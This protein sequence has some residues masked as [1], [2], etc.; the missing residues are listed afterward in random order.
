MQRTIA[1][2]RRMLD[3][4]NLAPARRREL[5]REVDR[6][7]GERVALMHRHQVDHIA[8][9]DAT[10]GNVKSALYENKVKVRA[11]VEKGKIGDMTAAEYGARFEELRR[12]RERLVKQAES[13]ESRV[14]DVARMEDDAEGY[15]DELFERFP[16][17]R[18]D[19][20]F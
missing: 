7:V 5:Q 11:L 2:A 9:L 1:E 13:I 3:E 4:Q 15:L 19:F 20:P 14:E 8:M 16:A 18:P 10:I 12:D 17:Q 6:I